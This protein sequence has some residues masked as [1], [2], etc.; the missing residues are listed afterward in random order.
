MRQTS[1]RAPPH[2]V[3]LLVAPEPPRIGAETPSAL[4]TLPRMS[5]QADGC[6][7][8]WTAT[9]T[10]NAP[11]GRRF[12]TAVWT[13]SEMIVWGG[14]GGSLLNPGGKY[15]PGTDSW[16]ATSTMNAPSG[17]YSHTAVWTGSEI[18][19]WGGYDGNYL[20]TGGKYNPDTDAWT[21]TSTANAP[22]GRDGTRCSLDGQ[23]NDRLG[24]Y[25]EALRFF[26]CGQSIQSWHEYLDGGGSTGRPP[27]EGTP[28]QSGPAAKWRSG[29]DLL[30][31]RLE[32][33]REI[34]SQH[35]Q[36]DGHQHH[37]CARWAQ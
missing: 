14:W 12:H 18:V 35:E 8:T 30:A 31:Q 34:Q 10:T 32:R 21:A 25:E 19:V 28:A 5:D 37:Q 20:N 36:L 4:Y 16:T 3:A 17:R 11:I 22:V 23:R 27:G 7:D 2:S 15:T 6:D 1:R 13:G 9:S 24:G 26:P 29:A 33:R